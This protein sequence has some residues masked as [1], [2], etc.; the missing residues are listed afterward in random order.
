MRKEDLE[1]YKKTKRG[2]KVYPTLNRLFID[3]IFCFLCAIFLVLT[4]MITH[5]SNW[6]YFFAVI[7]V[8][9]GIFFI[10]M[11]NKY[12][13]REIIRMKKAI[14]KKNDKVDKK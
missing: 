8:I 13:E 1:A 11:S 6:F 10:I 2:N 12:K 4:T 9:A 14:K 3:G 5:D 7:L